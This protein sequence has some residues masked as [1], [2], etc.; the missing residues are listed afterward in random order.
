MVIYLAALSGLERKGRELDA[1]DTPSSL[2]ALHSGPDNGGLK[3]D[4]SNAHKGRDLRIF[5]RIFL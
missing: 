2:R 1:Q 4:L 3:V 5:D